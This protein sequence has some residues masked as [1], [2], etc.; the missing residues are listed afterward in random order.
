M[1]DGDRPLADGA[2]PLP[3]SRRGARWRVGVGPGA[4][5][6]DGGPGGAVE[7]GSPRSRTTPGPWAHTAR[8]VA[9]A[10]ATGPRDASDGGPQVQVRGA[11]PLARRLRLSLGGAAPAGPAGALL[12]VV[13]H[14]HVVPPEVGLA[15]ARSGRTLLPVVVQ[16]RRVVVGPVTTPEGPCLHCLDLHR[17]DRDAHWPLVATHLGHPVEQISPSPVPESLQ[18]AVEGLVLLLVDAIREGRPVQPGLSHE[19]GPHPPHVVLR[20][21]AT[22]HRCPWH[23]G[24]PAGGSGSGSGWG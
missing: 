7:G 17:C 5:V 18:A 20:R 12:E 15:A 6:V 14:Q 4:V 13:V 22:H 8:R 16:P 10:L 19:V 2:V 9:A 11:G 1:R 24:W 3:A 21:W 23:T